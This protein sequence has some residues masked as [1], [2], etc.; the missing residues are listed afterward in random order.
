MCICIGSTAQRSCLVKGLLNRVP[1][2]PH[3]TRQWLAI[4]APG[5]LLSSGGLV[6]PALAPSPSLPFLSAVIVKASSGPRYV[7][8]CRT[9]VDKTK[10]KT[11]TRVALDMTTLTIMRALPREVGLQTLG[12]HHWASG[13]LGNTPPQGTCITLS[14]PCL[15]LMH[16][17]LHQIRRSTMPGQAIGGPDAS[18]EESNA[19]VLL[20][21]SAH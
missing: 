1:I 13:R 18:S 17:M 8:G 6:P 11:T 9:K 15:W 12:A 10:L 20:S 16:L 19:H 5:H 21:S 14:A 3:I 2:F 4:T 7:V